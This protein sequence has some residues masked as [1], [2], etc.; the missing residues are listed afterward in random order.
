MAWFLFSEAAANAGF[1]YTALHE[2]CLFS[3]LCCGS[4]YFS[5]GSRGLGSGLAGLTCP[6]RGNP[7]GSAAGA[8]GSAWL[9]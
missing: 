6:E 3:H 9:G 1:A 5:F 8:A 2:T 4:L 7:R